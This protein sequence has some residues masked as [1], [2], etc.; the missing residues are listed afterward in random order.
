MWAS[1]ALVLIDCEKSIKPLI[2]YSHVGSYSK[3]ITEYK[4]ICYYQIRKTDQ[5]HIDKRIVSDPGKKDL[6]KVCSYYFYFPL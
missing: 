2:G 5:R 1:I 6:P 3:N 4:P